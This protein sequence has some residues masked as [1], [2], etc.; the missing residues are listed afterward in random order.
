MEASEANRP[1]AVG[2][3]NPRLKRLLAAAELR[4]PMLMDVV[5]EKG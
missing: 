4:E 5:A 1:R 3:E 2:T